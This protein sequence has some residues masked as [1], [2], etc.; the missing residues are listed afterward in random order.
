MKIDSL[1]K[2]LVL[3][4]VLWYCHKRGREVRLEKE[5]SDAAEMEGRV[6]ELSDAD[7]ASVSTTPLALESR[8]LPALIEPAPRSTFSRK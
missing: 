6:E 5:K 7:S 1:T 4:F 8:P 2:N 3:M